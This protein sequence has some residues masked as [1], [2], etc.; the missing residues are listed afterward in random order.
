[1]NQREIIEG[2]SIAGQ[3]TAEDIAR[4]RDEGFKTI[5]N[6]R[7]PEDNGILE[8]EEHIVEGSGLNYAAIPVSPTVVDDLAVQR[9]S[10]A[11][12]DKESRPALIHCGSGGRAG[13]MLLLH[14]AIEHG[15]SVE[16]T[17][18]E[19]AKLGDLAPS[20]TS[21]YRPFFEGYIKRHSAGERTGE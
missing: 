9:F 7:L 18:E 17:L 4:L 21:A 10:Q 15:W 19:G 2:I 6:L 13:I 1:M 14:L 3:P 20:E 12:Y 11:I 5:V 16:R 8:D